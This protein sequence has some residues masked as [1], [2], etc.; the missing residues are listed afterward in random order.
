MRANFLPPAVRSIFFESRAPVRPPDCEG[1]QGQQKHC[2]TRLSALQPGTHSQRSYNHAPPSQALQRLSP[3]PV[4]TLP[5]SPTSLGWT[6]HTQAALQNTSSN[7]TQ[8]RCGS[9]GLALAGLGACRGGGRGAVCGRW[10]CGL[11]RATSGSDMAGSSRQLQERGARGPGPGSSNAVLCRAIRFK[12]ACKQPRAHGRPDHTT[13]HG[14]R[15]CPRPHTGMRQSVVFG[16]SG[17]A[18]RPLPFQDS[19]L[20][21]HFPPQAHERISFH[22]SPSRNHK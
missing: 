21:S 6:I 15:P 9:P 11:G 14:G 13:H 1:G 19:P 5:A 10:R 22:G 20:A 16:G 18:A 7:D 12:A 3:R 8:V 4:R 17:S 2:C